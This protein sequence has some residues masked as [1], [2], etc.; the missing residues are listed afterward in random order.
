M[1]S[2]GAALEG[3][4]AVAL[5]G[6]RGIGRATAIKLALEGASVVIAARTAS[7][8]NDVGAEIEMETNDARS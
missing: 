2:E 4:V 3:K 7:K 6:R 8:L 1:G 5:G